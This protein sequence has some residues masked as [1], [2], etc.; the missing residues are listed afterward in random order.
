MSGQLGAWFQWTSACVTITAGPPV[1]IWLHTTSSA[2]GFSTVCPTATTVA[3][4]GDDAHGFN[5]DAVLSGPPW[6]AIY[7]DVPLRED[8]TH[9]DC[10]VLRVRLVSRVYFVAFCVSS[11]GLKKRDIAVPC[12]PTTWGRRR[13]APPQ[14]PAP[15]CPSCSRRRRWRNCAVIHWTGFTARC[16]HVCQLAQDEVCA[17][18]QRVFGARACM[19]GHVHAF[20]SRVASLLARRN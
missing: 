7:I 19:A 4:T 20:Q 13:P 11:A 6:C 15:C 1:T 10:S 17:L 2:G 9:C 12:S 14:P 3:C 5:L 8:S 18:P 16:A